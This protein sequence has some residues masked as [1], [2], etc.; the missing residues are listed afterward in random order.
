MAEIQ[1]EKNTGLDVQEQLDKAELFFEKNKKNISIIAGVIIA[2]AGLISLYKFW[3]IPSEDAKAQAE[4]FTA[5][6]YFEKDSLDLALNGGTIAG[7][8]FT[9]LLDVA[10][11]YS[12]TPTGNLAEYMIGTILLKKGKFEE[13]IEHLSNFKSDDIMISAVALGAIGDANLEL[14]KSDEALNFYLKAA[15]TNSNEFTSPIYLKKAALVYES[16]REFAEA[17]KNFERIKKEF[18]K[19]TEARD[20]EK[21]ISRVKVAGNLE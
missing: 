14:N 15:N 2:V 5:Q 21:Y 4:I 13:A 7:Q 16:K 9:G 20:I 8:S 18:N 10:D 1:D 3:Y 12:G 11:S 6:Q 17:L 19:S